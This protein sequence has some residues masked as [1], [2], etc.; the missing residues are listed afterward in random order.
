[1]DFDPTGEAPLMMIFW[2]GINGTTVPGYPVQYCTR[3]LQSSRAPEQQSSRA[4]LIARGFLSRE[5]E[6]RLRVQQSSISRAVK[7]ESSSRRVESSSHQN[8]LLM[9]SRL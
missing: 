3:S 8:I 9:R 4:S 1:M 6:T 2:S 5:V 7:V